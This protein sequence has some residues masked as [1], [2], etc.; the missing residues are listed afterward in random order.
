MPLR[1]LS[2]VRNDWFKLL[3][4][5]DPGWRASRFGA[6]LDVID[7]LVALERRRLTDPDAF[8][9]FRASLEKQELLFE[10]TSQLLSLQL[11]RKA[12]SRLSQDVLARKVRTVLS[13]EP[14]PRK[15]GAADEPRD[16]LVEL[17]A[18]ALFANCGF[19]AGVTANDED[20][21]LA[22][23]GRNDAIVVECKRPTGEETLP[24]ALGK[25][26][27]QLWK[28]GKNKQCM[29]VI[30]V[31]RVH[32]FSGALLKADADADVDFAVSL[33]MRRTIETI[34][35]ICLEPR[36]RLSA[37]TVGIVTFTAAVWVRKPTSHLYPSSTHLP[38]DIGD[39]TAVPDWLVRQ[40]NRREDRLLDEF[41]V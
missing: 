2:E 26:R 16:T 24:T 22:L 12:W 31:E 38:F 6:Y 1:S 21:H 9:E 34:R 33:C 30:A 29:A 32:G 17:L 14:L 11:A 20:L 18:A 10:A 28:R 5:T 4:D 8:R 25:L 15:D 36:Y 27:R 7:E 19:D 13:G 37:S 23:A 35:K 40:L 39:G 3:G 41:R